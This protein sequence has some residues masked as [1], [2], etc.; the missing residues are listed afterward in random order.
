MGNLS[1]CKLT[2]QDK[3]VPLTPWMFECIVFLK[4]NQELWRNADIV[5]AIKMVEGTKVADPGE[6]EVGG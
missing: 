6:Q 5:V 4:A 2:L 3:R 1:L